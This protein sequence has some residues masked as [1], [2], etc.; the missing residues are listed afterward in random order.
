[1]LLICV[2]LAGIAVNMF[3]NTP[4]TVGGGAGMIFVIIALAVIFK[5]TFQFFM[6]RWQKR[7]DEMSKREERHGV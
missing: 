5:A 7:K 4:N 6:N 1:M 3:I 2:I